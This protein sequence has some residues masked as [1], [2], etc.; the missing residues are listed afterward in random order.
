MFYELMTNGG[1][2]REHTNTNKNNYRV[3]ANWEKW[4]TEHLP[5][6]FGLDVYEICTD[7]KRNH[8]EGTDAILRNF[9]GKR[10][11]RVDFKWTR[12]FDYKNVWFAL[13]NKHVDGTSWIDNEEAM[14]LDVLVLVP[15]KGSWEH[16]YKLCAYRLRDLHEIASRKRMGT[17]YC[18]AIGT[19]TTYFQVN[20]AELTDK[21]QWDSGWVNLGR[22]EANWN[23]TKRR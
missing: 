7:K 13:E 4:A 14:N 6:C 15:W 22:E 3:V 18:T 10:F 16:T 11:A 1:Y 2:H 9:C 20:E 12:I 23:K 21:C 8:D 17:S 5:S 19:G